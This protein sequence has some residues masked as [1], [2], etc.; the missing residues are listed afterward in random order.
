MGIL[1]RTNACH[2]NIMLADISNVSPEYIK[3]LIQGASK[4]N[5][6]G[7]S[8]K[9]ILACILSKLGFRP[10]QINRIIGDKYLC[11]L[12]IYDIWSEVNGRRPPSGQDLSNIA[13]HL[14]NHSFR[15][16]A[17]LFFGL[18]LARNGRIDHDIDDN[19]AEFIMAYSD[20]ILILSK[21]NQN[22]LFD[23][24]SMLLLLNDFRFGYSSISWEKCRKCQMKSLRIPRT[25]G[26]CVVCGH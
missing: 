23:A 3:H 13:F 7:L 4:P 21:F 26:K 22:P 10:K 9:I 14:T 12:R 5:F 24:R 20:F 25:C 17:S 6:L 19:L 2:K 16:Q 8:S 15:E 11:K 1:C 18:F